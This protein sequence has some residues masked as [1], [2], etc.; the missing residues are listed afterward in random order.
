[1]SSSMSATCASVAASRR[2]ALSPRSLK[3]AE[4]CL[5]PSK[6]KSSPSSSSARVN[7]SAHAKRTSRARVEDHE[8]SVSFV[9][10]DSTATALKCTAASVEGRLST[11]LKRAGETRDASAASTTLLETETAPSSAPPLFENGIGIPALASADPSATAHPKSSV[12]NA[13]ADRG[14]GHAAETGTR[15]SS[16]ETSTEVSSSHHFSSADALKSAGR[17]TGTPLPVDTVVP[18]SSFSFSFSFSCGSTK[19]HPLPAPSSSPPA[20]RA[21]SLRRRL[22]FY[23]PAPSS[24]SRNRARCSLKSS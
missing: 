22:F 17:R 14:S 10:F 9:V 12:S 24:D 2:D 18:L 11:P 5:P 23:A 13:H 4:R 21:Q 19:K 3:N 1:M 15:D 16:R 6:Y 8:S 20:T 7:F